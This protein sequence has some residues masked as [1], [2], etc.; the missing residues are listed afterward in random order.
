MSGQRDN[1]DE[2]R[3]ARLRSNAVLSRS[4]APDG[5]GETQRRQR[6]LRRRQWTEIRRGPRT[7]RI[8]LAAW[9][10]IGIAV[11]G[12]LA[13]AAAVESETVALYT[14]L[15]FAGLAVFSALLAVGVALAQGR[16]DVRQRRER[17][18]RAR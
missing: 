3:R 10:L 1:N 8:L 6:E 16:R 17:G 14:L 15:A 9:L 12:V 7:S 13:Y 4:R 18:T 11:V 5:L 2:P